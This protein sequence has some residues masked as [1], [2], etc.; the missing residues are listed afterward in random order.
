M[1]V[2]LT[3]LLQ[4]I[5]H[6]PFQS[7]SRGSRLRCRYP[8]NMSRLQSETEQIGSSLDYSVDF[9]CTFQSVSTLLVH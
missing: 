6:S 9:S 5:D 2:P 1:S 3:V 4:L 8:S 7:Q